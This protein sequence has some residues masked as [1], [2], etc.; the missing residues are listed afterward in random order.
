MYPGK[1]LHAL[2]IMIL[3]KGNEINRGTRPS[4]PLSFRQL[5]WDRGGGARKDS[6]MNTF[7]HQK[8][9]SHVHMITQARPLLVIDNILVAFMTHSLHNW[10][11]V[12]VS[13]INLIIK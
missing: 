9:V 5:R 6:W 2:V 3:S 10:L 8:Q 4:N 11:K 12:G 7:L 1:Y 13:F